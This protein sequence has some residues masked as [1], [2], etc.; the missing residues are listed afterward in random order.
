MNEADTN[1]TN[2]NPK[3]DTGAKRRSDLPL[4]AVPGIFEGINGQSLARA[5]ENIEKMTSVLREAYSS[6]ARGAAYYAAKVIEFSAT[7]TS[8]AFDFLGQVAG[9]KS[10]S[11]AVQLSIIQARKTFEATTSQSRELWEIARK[12]ATETAEP[13]KE[14]IAGTRQKAA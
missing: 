6:N 8:S 7:N 11:E 4:F 3:G 14:G 5:T 12:V 2:I 13:I 10:P 1:E 9:S